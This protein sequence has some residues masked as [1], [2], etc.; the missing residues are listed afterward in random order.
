M[1]VFVALIMILLIG[2][3]GLAVDVGHFSMVKTQLQNAADAGALAGAAAFQTT[4]DPYNEAIFYVKQNKSDNVNLIEAD[5]TCQDAGNLLTSC[6]V[7][8]AVKIQVTIRR[9]PG[10]NGNGGPVPTYFAKILN[11]SGAFD[12]VPVA[13][14][15]KAE[16]KAGKP[17]LIPLQ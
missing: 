7:P 11:T 3:L 14:S 5:I 2:F 1:I 4:R 15:A 13:A 6:T 17:H 16:L 9:A 8:A 12:T 10:S